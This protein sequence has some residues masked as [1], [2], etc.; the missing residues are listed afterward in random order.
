MKK[1]FYKKPSFWRRFTIILFLIFIALSFRPIINP[2]EKDCT[3][4]T[5]TLKDYKYIKEKRDI[6]IIV[7]NSSKHYYINNISEQDID[8]ADLE[9][10]K[11]KDIVLY[12]VNHW[13]LLDPKQNNKHIARLSN[14]AETQILYTEF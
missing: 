12:V 3:K 8:F 7:E 1:Q 6:H 9:R 10:L 2:K 11:G 14:G 4:I 13:T 5:L